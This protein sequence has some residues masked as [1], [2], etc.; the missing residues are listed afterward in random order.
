VSAGP[1]SVE[2]QLLLLD[3][4]LHVAASAVDVLVERSRVMLED[5]E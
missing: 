3:A 5:E 4:V 2:V 1:V